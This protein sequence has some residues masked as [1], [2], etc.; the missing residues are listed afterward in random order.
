MSKR[1][2]YFT[3]WRKIYW[4][5]AHYLG[6]LVARYARKSPRRITIDRDIWKLLRRI[7]RLRKRLDVEGEVMD[8]TWLGELYRLVRKEGDRP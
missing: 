1:P 3:D 4:K 6:I 2:V 7:E 8:I 5:E